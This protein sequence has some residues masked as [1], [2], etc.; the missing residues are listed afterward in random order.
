MSLSKPELRQAFDYT[1]NQ[2]KKRIDL[3]E[4]AYFLLGDLK[5]IC[6]D[7]ELLERI[8]TARTKMHKELWPWGA[9]ETNEQP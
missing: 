7:R 4:E 9:A 2:C 3:I 8:K 6:A 5:P 1:L